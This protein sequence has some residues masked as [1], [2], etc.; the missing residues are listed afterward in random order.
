MAP[1][2]LLPPKPPR[3]G[4]GVITSLVLH[5]LVVAPFLFEAR[6]PDPDTDPIDQLVVFLVPPDRPGG[7]GGSGPPAKWTD[8]AGTSGITETPPPPPPPDASDAID[9]GR[10][11]DPAPEDTAFVGRMVAT[12]SA[13]S[14]VEVDSVVERDPTSA[15]PVYPEALLLKQ[16]EGTTRVHYVVDT[17]G[18]VDSTTIRVIRTTAPEFAASVRAALVV[19]KFRPAM[20]SSHRVR[21]WVEQSFSFRILPTER[22]DTT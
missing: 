9:L 20:Q 5:L 4:I 6:R 14:E 12:E 22:R 13:L 21:Q 7:P 1:F 11:G 8:P 10:P 15:A 19:M 16:I 17:T 2:E 3:G 18:R